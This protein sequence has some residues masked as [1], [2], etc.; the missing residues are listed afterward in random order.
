ML[1]S[2]V[3]VRTSWPSRHAGSGPVVVARV[4]VGPGVVGRREGTWIV[5]GGGGDVAAVV[6]FD[7]GDTGAVPVAGFAAATAAVGT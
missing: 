2:V 1:L 6:V 4:V 3:T 7:V 5:V